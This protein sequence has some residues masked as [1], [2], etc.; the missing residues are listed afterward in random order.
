MTRAKSPTSTAILSVLLFTSACQEQEP[1]EPPDGSATPTASGETF[2]A[3]LHHKCYAIRGPGAEVANID[4][5]SQFSREAVPL[6]SPLSL[7]TPTIKITPEREHGTL[8]SSDLKCYGIMGSDPDATIRLTTQQFG[9]E[10]HKVGIAIAVCAPVNIA[11]A[12]DGRPSQSLPRSPYYTCH[13]IEGAVPDHP[14]VDLKT[15]H[16]P[17]EKA[18]QINRPYAVCAPAVKDAGDDPEGSQAERERL[19]SV[20]PHLK[21]YGIEGPPLNRAYNMVSILGEERGVTVMQ[22][23]GFCVPATK[24]HMPDKQDGLPP[25]VEG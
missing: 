6:G 13:Q 1:P 2:L 12:P 8:S 23:Q 14:A 15:T 20:F 10:V 16:F 11:P 3:D 21:C 18:V 9:S 7:C 17:L 5:T 22:P 24:E 25:E 4:F 19:E